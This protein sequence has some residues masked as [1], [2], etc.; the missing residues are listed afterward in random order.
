MNRLIRAL[1]PLL[2]VLGVAVPIYAQDT[3][4]KKLDD[5]AV[6]LYKQG[7]WGCNILSVN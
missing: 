7:H 5:E 1:L 4:W 6:S 3:E 2:L